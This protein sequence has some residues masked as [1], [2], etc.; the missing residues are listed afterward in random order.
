MHPT[1][2]VRQPSAQSAMGLHSSSQFLSQSWRGIRM[3]EADAEAAESLRQRT[4]PSE[5]AS[6]SGH[7]LPMAAV[8]ITAE[9]RIVMC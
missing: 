5:R 8:K 6:G 4:L 7:N 2:S 9:V 3:L 1:V